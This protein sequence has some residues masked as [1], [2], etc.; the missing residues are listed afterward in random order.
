MN[1]N[2]NPK[3][4][5][6]DGYG[7]A[8]SVRIQIERDIYAPNPRSEFDHNGI[9]ILGDDSYWSGDVH[10]AREVYGRRDDDGDDDV[11]YYVV[12]GNVTGQYFYRSALKAA[13]RKGKKVYNPA[14]DR[15]EEVVILP[16]WI[17]PDSGLA[18]NDE[19]DND[20][21]GCDGYAII[22]RSVALAATKDWQDWKVLTMRRRQ[23]VREWLRGEIRE[24]SD[25]RTGNVYIASVE[26][27]NPQTKEWEDVDSCGAFYGDAAKDEARQVAEAYQRKGFDVDVFVDYDYDHTYD[28]DMIAQQS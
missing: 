26:E 22:F 21:S 9:I 5:E 8:A 24:Y 14:T 16:V 4:N 2:Y 15:D 1:M 27:W 13:F 17:N 25:Y 28:G 7:P 12:S 10:T 18:T 3:D 20:D 11:C 23:Q 6:Q 19:G